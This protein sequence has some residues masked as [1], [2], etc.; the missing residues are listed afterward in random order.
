MDWITELLRHMHVWGLFLIA[1]GVGLFYLHLARR[2]AVSD[3]YGDKQNLFLR[4]LLTGVVFTLFAIG[5]VWYIYPSEGV[6]WIRALD[7]LSWII[8]STAMVVVLILAFFKTVTMRW[9]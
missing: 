3:K 7:R 9:R 4:Q 5:G 6:E 8:V 1:F 2:L